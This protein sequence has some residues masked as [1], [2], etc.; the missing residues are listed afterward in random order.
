MKLS[1]SLPD[2]DLRFLDEY[3]QRNELPSRSAAIQR[4]VDTLRAF[5][6]GDAYERAWDEW[7]SGDGAD[8][9]SVAGDG[10]A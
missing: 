2:P 9:E 10:L 4:A 3:A 6:L 1:I 7:E 8:W 5:E